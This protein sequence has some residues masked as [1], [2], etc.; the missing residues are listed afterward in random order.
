[1]KIGE[2][3]YFVSDQAIGYAQRPKYQV[4]ICDPSWIIDGH[5]FQFISG[6]DYGGDI[7]ITHA[8]YGFLP[9][10]VSYIS[11]GNPASYSVEQLY[12][13][14]PKLK[15]RLS[16]EHMKLLYDGVLDSF[17]MERRFIPL[18]AGTIL[19]AIK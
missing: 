11:C 1:M 14:K 17:T 10:A 12:E 3:Y 16:L 15:G 9:Y 2:I 4:Y 13:L 18:I 19:K 6:R 8:E 7:R 5:T